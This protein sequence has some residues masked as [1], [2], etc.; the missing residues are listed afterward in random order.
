MYSR[1]R[2]FRS[3]TLLIALIS[4]T[5]L[6]LA[7]FETVPGDFNMYFNAAK[8]IRVSQDPY[9]ATNGGRGGYIYGPILACALSLL[10]S[11]S[12]L[13][14]AKIWF[15]FNIT[16][17]GLTIFLMKRLWLNN[18]QYNPIAIYIGLILSFSVRNNFGNGQVMILVAFLAL[19]AIYICSQ[20]SSPMTDLFASLYLVIAF[21]LKPYLI[22]GIV[23]LLLFKRR[24]WLLLF[25]P[26][27]SCILNLM[28]FYLAR[29]TWL[30]WLNALRERAGWVSGATDQAS[31]FSTLQSFLNLDIITASVITLAISG[32]AIFLVVKNGKS[33]LFSDSKW[34]EYLG[35]ALPCILSPF[36][37]S[38]DFLFVTIVALS[39]LSNQLSIGSL[40]AQT[41][42]GIFLSM[43]VNWTNENLVIGLVLILLYFSNIYLNFKY[44]N[45]WVICVSALLA[46]IQTILIHIFS[47]SSFV[48]YNFC[49]SVSG[50][51]G[52]FILI[53]AAGAFSRA[54]KLTIKSL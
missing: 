24:F 43:Q 54:G 44:I 30:E 53:Q 39:I 42:L 25:I 52:F 3:A 50:L 45:P 20:N 18:P 41:L 33:F 2:I 28:Y 31:L 26:I 6:F 22:L 49:V 48:I 46:A 23:A 1:V 4:T 17:L 16:F 11:F 7:Y 47:D 36:M 37:H 15:L 12:A 5:F 38:H 32:F 34:V 9:L 8:A 29:V 10:S 51:V 13:I 14:V 35:L 21:E 40:R 27:I 19:A